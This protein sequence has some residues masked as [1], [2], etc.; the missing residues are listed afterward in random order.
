MF[1]KLVKSLKKEVVFFEKSS[2]SVSVK[3]IFVLKGFLVFVAF[4]SLV[5]LAVGIFSGPKTI[6]NE[7]NSFKS[8]I[9]D[10]SIISSD[11]SII[12]FKTI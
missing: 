10:L 8:S 5:F 11:L 1:R 9:I 3:P 7:Y 12:Y 6:I 2:F 4:S